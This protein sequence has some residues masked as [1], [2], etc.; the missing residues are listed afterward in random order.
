MVNSYHQETFIILK[1]NVMSNSNVKILQ[2]KQNIWKGNCKYPIEQ[3]IFKKW[4]RLMTICCL[5]K[6]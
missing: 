1:S 4:R 3:E 5:Q 6:I 2:Y